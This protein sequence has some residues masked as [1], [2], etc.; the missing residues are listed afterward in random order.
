MPLSYP[1]D[2]VA[3]FLAHHHVMTLATTGADGPW[4]AAVFY[5]SD[6]PGLVFLS[7][8]GSRH[9]RDLALDARSAATIQPDYDDWPQIRGIQLAGR[10]S[11]LQG[12]DEAAARRCYALRFPI[13][14]PLGQA[15]AAIA[16]ALAKVR[17][18]RLLPERMYFIDNRAGFGRRREI[19][20]AAR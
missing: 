17:W 20:L 4:A 3:D 6:G 16:Q 18:Y 10:V 9:A 7:S 8:P 11:L 2:E 19:D 15:P 1:P 12:D 13:A 5:A 14:G